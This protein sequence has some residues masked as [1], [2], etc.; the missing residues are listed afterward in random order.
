[1]HNLPGN[2]YYTIASYLLGTR[3]K[4]SSKSLTNI[5]VKLLPKYT[6]GLP[7]PKSVKEPPFSEDVPTNCESPEVTPK[8]ISG[9]GAPKHHK[10]T[11]TTVTPQI[12]SLCRL[13]NYSVLAS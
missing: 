10:L 6:M 1:M 2:A 4:P 12:I 3:Y 8:F 13:E 11:N 7:N 9:A 5:D